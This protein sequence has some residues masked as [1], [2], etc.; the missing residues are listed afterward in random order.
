MGLPLPF[1]SFLLLLGSSNHGN[2]E[3]ERRVSDSRKL[4]EVSRE[5][6]LCELP[7]KTSFKEESSNL[8]NLTERMDLP[9]ASVIKM[10][11]SLE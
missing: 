6:S 7:K 1:P 9:T 11:I 8:I 10:I 4:L 2:G 3:D 5:G